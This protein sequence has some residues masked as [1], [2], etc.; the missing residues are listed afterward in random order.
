MTSAGKEIFEFTSN[1]LTDGKTVSVTPTSGEYLSADEVK[2][3]YSGNITSWKSLKKD[4]S[5]KVAYF[6]DGTRAYMAG[7][8]KVTE[9]GFKC[10]Y[11]NYNSKEYCGKVFLVGATYYI[12]N[13]DGNKAMVSFTVK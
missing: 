1:R 13:K 11:W 4:K 12:T 2:Q 3:M 6:V 7:T 9:D 8:W 5:G 10:N